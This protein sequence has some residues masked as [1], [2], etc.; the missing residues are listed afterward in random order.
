MKERESL[1]VCVC[2]RGEVDKVKGDLMTTKNE[3][4]SLRTNP[5]FQRTK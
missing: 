1:C 4:W 3:Y 2:G 5:L